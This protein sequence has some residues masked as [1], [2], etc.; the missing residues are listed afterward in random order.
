ME[1]SQNG[2]DFIEG[3]EDL[4]TKAYPDP[5]TKAAPYTIGFGTTRYPSGMPVHLGDVCTPEQAT[6]YLINDLAQPQRTVNASV[7]VPMNQNQFDALVS[8]V[9]NLGSGN[10]VKSTLLKKLNQKDYNGA[11]DE[12]LK[13]ISPGTSVSAGLLRRRTAERAMFL[14]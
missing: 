3:F 8:F 4:R 1:V 14:S 12:F 6:Q 2:I 13:W 5:K 10:F 11:A 9:Q 7:E